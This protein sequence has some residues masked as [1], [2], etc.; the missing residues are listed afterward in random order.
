MTRILLLTLALA[1]CSS[2]T[3]VDRTTPHERA[4]PA[5]EAM[6]DTTPTTAAQPA[7]R[8][9]GYLCAHDR[10]PAVPPYCPD[11]QIPS[12]HGEGGCY[13][14]CVPIVECAC[15]ADDDCPAHLGATCGPSGLC[16][17]S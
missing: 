15:D 17:V 9:E 1:G 2:A 6:T 12:V 4:E 11:G 14:D 5:A 10:C 13:G 16:Q 8:A 7:A 3:S